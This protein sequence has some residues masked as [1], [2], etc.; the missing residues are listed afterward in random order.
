MIYRNHSLRASKHIPLAL[1]LIAVPAFSHAQFVYS[2]STATCASDAGVQNGGS[3]AYD[4]TDMKSSTSLS[5]ANLS[6]SVDSTNSIGA[7]QYRNVASTTFD[8]ALTATG[9]R[10]DFTTNGTTHIL[11]GANSYYGPRA[12]GVVGETMSFQVTQSGAY[13]LKLTGSSTPLDNASFSGITFVGILT[14]HSSAGGSATFTAASASHSIT[15]IQ[16]SVNLVAGHSYDFA[17]FDE[18]YV[19]Q[20]GNYGPIPAESLSTN[21]TVILGAPT[22]EPASLMILGLGVV[23][24]PEDFGPRSKSFTAFWLG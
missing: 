9:A 4:K 6:T 20:P 5:G 7:M 19:I 18:G 8:T 23:G 16:T 10:F 11:S 14:D 21:G 2:A 24:S 22:P 17:W 12:D 13:A 15:S 3:S 1:L